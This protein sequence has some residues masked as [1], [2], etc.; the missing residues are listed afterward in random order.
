MNFVFGLGNPGKEYQNTRHNVGFEVL[1]KLVAA[2]VGQFQLAKNFSA[3]IY[4]TQNTLF[5]KPQTFMNESGKSVRAVLEYYEKT[6]TYTTDSE[7]QNLFVVHDDLDLELGNYKIQFGTGPKVHNGLNSIY[8]HLHTENFW[9]VRVGVD[10]R[11]GDR[12]IPPPNYVLARFPNDERE[13]INSV[14]EKIVAD[15]Q[16]KV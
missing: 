12:S 8:Q 2:E 11:K 13:I 14:I 10:A 15:L 7:F 6:A 5:A 16:K 3:E 1:D 4:K 9:H